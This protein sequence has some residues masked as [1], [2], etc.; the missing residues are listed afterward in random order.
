MLDKLNVK[1]GG[2]SDSHGIEALVDAAEVV[3]GFAQLGSM[4]LEIVT[5]QRGGEIRQIDVVAVLG[6]SGLDQQVDV[7]PI[8]L[9]MYS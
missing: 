4:F 6:D 5:P 2:I 9:A 3:I 8:L 1:R 7:L